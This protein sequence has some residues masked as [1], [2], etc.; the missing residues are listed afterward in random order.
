MVL[1]MYE[2]K[3]TN[4]LAL[5][6]LTGILLATPIIAISCASTTP[7]SRDTVS[8]EFKN[9]KT[10][11]MAGT[12]IGKL[13]VRDLIHNNDSALKQWIF[14]NQLTGNKNGMSSS[15]VVIRY[16]HENY[17]EGKLQAIYYLKEYWTTKGKSVMPSADYTLDVSGLTPID[18]TEEEIIDIINES[19]SFNFLTIDRFLPVITMLNLSHDSRQQIIDQAYLNKIK[20][21]SEYAN[22]NLT[23]I[24]G[25]QT[26]GTLTLKLTGM[27]QNVN[28]PDSLSI[29]TITGFKQNSTD[30]D[31]RSIMF[32]NIMHLNP[33][34]YYEDLQTVT[35]MQTWTNTQWI[36]YLQE[37]SAAGGGSAINL[38]DAIKNQTITNINFKN[39]GQALAT[40]IWNNFR[41]EFDYVNYIY[42]N[43]VWVIDQSSKQSFSYP[44]EINKELTKLTDADSM[45]FIANN[46]VNINTTEIAAKYTS[47]WYIRII[48]ELAPE[49]IGTFLTIDPVYENTYFSDRTI[50]LECTDTTFTVDDWNGTFNINYKLVLPDDLSSPFNHGY[51]EIS[52]ALKMSDYFAINTQNIS[53]NVTLVNKPSS[54]A[55]RI[56]KN[57]KDTYSKAQLEA[58]TVNEINVIDKTPEYFSPNNTSYRIYD[59]GAG[60]D[61]KINETL[62]NN[63]G[64]FQ[65]FNKVIS[66][67][68]INISNNTFDRDNNGG[69]YLEFLTLDFDPNTKATLTKT[70]NGLFQ[71]KVAYTYDVA[72]LGSSH[73]VQGYYFINISLTDLGYN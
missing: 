25:S 9:D 2:K 43:N 19:G 3:S 5:I 66:R 30:Y 28:I 15:L 22:L 16:T 45:Q 31:L 17:T 49:A 23:L 57:I 32:V 54:V 71:Y 48:E 53:Y 20:S 38:L 56:F 26:S 61:N 58:F 51:K 50:I 46:K 55:T 69:F 35:L 72:I 52:G 29:I 24:S 44:M 68:N 7:A 12:E 14:D 10:A 47:Y 73:P 41:L 70:N 11:N 65:I 36:K 67:S 1:L 40:N 63:T 39:I 42:Q 64:Q 59:S 62:I 13:S 6:L 4:L 21:V 18:P 8:T 27:F 34:L 37:F 60:I 33:N